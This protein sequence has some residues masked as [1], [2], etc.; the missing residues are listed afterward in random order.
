MCVIAKFKTSILE[1]TK[2]IILPSVCTFVRYETLLKIGLLGT[3]DTSKVS[4]ICEVFLRNIKLK[5]NKVKAIIK[6]MK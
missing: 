2:P 4:D 3:S 1:K 5:V 6:L